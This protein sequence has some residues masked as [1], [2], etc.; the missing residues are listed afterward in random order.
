[1]VPLCSKTF[2][3]LLFWSRLVHAALAINA[4]LAIFQ[5]SPALCPCEPCRPR[6][7][8]QAVPCGARFDTR[9]LPA[10]SSQPRSP[11]IRSVR[12]YNSRIHL[13]FKGFSWA[14]ASGPARPGRPGRASPS[15][16]P[17]MSRGPAR[18]IKVSSG[19]PH[20]GPAIQFFRRWAA[21]RPGPSLFQRMGL[22]P[23]QPI[24]FSK[25]HGPAMTWQRGP[26]NIG[27]VRA[28]PT[29]WWAGP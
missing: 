16:I 27:F 28:G 24:T 15:N 18:P 21:V 2:S 1:M 13:Y 9:L 14:D 12:T 25:I 23:A 19:G 26:S 5:A 17:L 11:Q 6:G 22:G 29:L 20:P 10:S 4:T 7:E 3:L 8:M